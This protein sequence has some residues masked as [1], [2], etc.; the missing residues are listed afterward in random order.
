MDPLL[1]HRYG[2]AN[3]YSSMRVPFWLFGFLHSW[4]TGL[5]VPA[6]SDYSSP[7]RFATMTRMIMHRNG[8]FLPSR[9]LI[10]FIG[11]VQILVSSQA[12]IQV[13][14]GNQEARWPRATLQEKGVYGRSPMR[15]GSAWGVLIEPI[16]EDAN[17]VVRRV[18]GSQHV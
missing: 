5:N 6:S 9:S 10:L 14:Q 11:P 16:H 15:T 13:Q 17:G 2:Y 12:E 8:M 7:F 18:G 3:T 4:A 1:G